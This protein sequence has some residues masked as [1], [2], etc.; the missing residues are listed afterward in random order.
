MTTQLHSRNPATDELIDSL[1]IMDADEVRAA[2][3]RARAASHW[4]GAQGFSGRRV[5]LLAWRRYMA[6]HADEIIE[7]IHRENGKPRAD[8]ALELLLS[9]EHITWTAKHASKILGR[10]KRRPG[11]LMSNF[12]AHVEHVPFGVVGVIG[13]WNYPLYTPNGSISTALA[14][15][16]TVVFK[17]S[18]YTPAV[19]R[20]YVDAFAAAN[21]QAP[22]GVLTLVTGDGATGAALCRA[23]IDKLAF[24]G[25]TATGRKVMSTCAEN[26]VPV[27]MELGGKDAAIVAAD[28]DIKSAAEAIA[29]G[30]MG[31]SGQTCVGIE[32]VYVERSIRD[33]FLSELKDALRDVSPGCAATSSYGPMTMPGQIDLV[34]RHVSDALAEGA[35]AV[36]GGIDSIGDRYIEPIILVDP[37][38]TS[39]SIQEE[40]FGPTLTV[41]T[42]DSLDDAINLANDVPFGLAGSVFS[43]RQASRIA[44]DLDTGQVSLNSVLGFAAIAS[45]PLGGRGDSGFG[46]IHGPEGLLEFTRTRAVATQ[47]F[48]LP[49]IALLSFRRPEWLDRALPRLITWLHG[50]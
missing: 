24:T 46:R 11:L 48:P 7:L 23:G 21:P 9:L 6:T 32:R 42:V 10:E 33:R 37:P 44:R 43:R 16:N 2:T 18:E 19:A 1:P 20:W 38:H 34:R 3:D 8:A 25:S 41:T 30:A 35:Q 31:N 13:P 5:A 12:S 49:G 26:L 27:V 39:S 50:H 17:P 40:T 4:W 28:A 36:M 29:F 14:A 15:G 47:R 45:L 22:G